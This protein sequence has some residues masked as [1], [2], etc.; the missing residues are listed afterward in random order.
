ML[1]P[2]SPD[3]LPG[4]KPRPD[5]EVLLITTGDT[6]RVTGGNLYNR[7]VL[8]GLGQAG[9]SSAQMA[10]PPGPLPITTIRLQARLAL[11]P[12]KILIVDSLALAQTAALVPWIKDRLQTR[13]VALMH[14]LPS[15]LASPMKRVPLQTSESMLLRAADTVVAVSPYLGAKLAARGA[16]DR[17]EVIVPGR[18]GVG[19]S[20]AIAREHDHQVRF[21]CVANW[22]PGKGIDLLVR[23][24]EGLSNQ[25]RLDLVGDSG[26]SSYSRRVLSLIRLGKLEDR[27]QLH[28]VL[29]GERLA[30]QYATADAFVLPSRSEGF[31]TVYAEAMSFG[32][33]VV[34]CRV[35][36]IPWLVRDECGLLVPTGCLSALR[37][38]METLAAN[39]D[40]RGRMGRA[41]RDRALLLPT[42]TE[43]IAR[44]R[45]LICRLVQ[46]R[47]D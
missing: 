14:M 31:G 2:E 41:A 23:A 43:S 22:S 3:G 38:T 36:P 20:E 37:M 34:A 46:C 30:R 21:L 10:M 35:G 33:P 9:I 1:R 4:G 42:W 27:V 26:E 5:A 13:V 19:T 25:V 8:E 6:S 7:R 24:M 11:H 29:E 44:F 17:V 16:A 28:G 39:P 12:P 18:D 15:D 47:S 45:R 32:L 40:V